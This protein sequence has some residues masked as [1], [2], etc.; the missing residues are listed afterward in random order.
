MVIHLAM[1][2]NTISD[3][4]AH[5]LAEVL[6]LNKTLEVL[7]IGD[8]RISSVGATDIARALEVN[9]GILSLMLSGNGIAGPGAQ[10]L[11]HALHT[12][13]TLQDLQVAVGCFCVFRSGVHVFSFPFSQIRLTLQTRVRRACGF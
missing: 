2:W 10:E 9:T 12:N 13:T 5:D 4:G 6:K 7:D 3:P 11:A 8:N 1:S